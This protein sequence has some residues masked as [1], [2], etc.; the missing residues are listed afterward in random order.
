M[1][2]IF[3]FKKAGIVLIS[4]TLLMIL[5]CYPYECAKGIDKGL[6]YSCE[7]I[8][9]SLFP[10]IVLSSFIIRSGAGHIIGKLFLPITRYLFNLPECAGSA[11]IL[12]FIGGFPVGAKCVSLL[13]REKK[14]T[15]AEAERMMKFCVCSGPAFMITAIGTVMLNSVQAGWILYISQILSCVLIGTILG[16]VERLQNHSVCGKDSKMNQQNKISVITYLIEASSDGANSVISMTALILMFSL[17]GN[18]IQCSGLSEMLTFI[19]DKIGINSRISSIIVPMVLEVTGGCS[20]IREASL[21]IW[22]FSLCVGFGGMCVHFQIFEL[23]KGIPVRR[24][25]Y[26]LFR[27]INAVTSA[28]I[29]YLICLIYRPT[30]GV[31]AVGGGD[32]A[33]ISAATYMGSLALIVMSVLFVLTLQKSMLSYSVGIKERK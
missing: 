8:I 18:V 17:L 33:H 22:F 27:L 9:P 2:S 10:Y 32:E 24:S 14:I 1:F 23:I 15:V 19:L 5:V 20:A 26:L 31:F 16:T 4:C 13:Y 25:V 28:F 6:Q 3:T 29:T 11:V 12:S 30:A 21:P 7:I